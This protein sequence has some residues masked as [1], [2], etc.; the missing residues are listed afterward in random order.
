VQLT[1]RIRSERTQQLRQEFLSQLLR[2][3]PAAINEIELGKLNSQPA[4]SARR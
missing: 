4:P 2:D 1:A 3:H